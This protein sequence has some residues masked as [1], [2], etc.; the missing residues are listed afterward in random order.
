M[1][2][3]RLWVRNDPRRATTTTRKGRSGNMDTQVERVVGYVRVSTSHQAAHGWSLGEQTRHITAYCAA[4]NW[5]LAEI[6]EDAGISGRTTDRPRLSELL[7]ELADI[8]VI[9]VSSLSRLGRSNRHLQ[10][11][12]ADLEA[13]GVALVSLAESID[14]STASGKLMRNFL[15]AIAEFESEQTSERV[16]S[17]A[18]ARVR[19][20]H[21]HGGPPPYGYTHRR[22]PSGEPIKHEPWMIVPAETAIVIRIFREYLEGRSQHAIVRGLKA[23]GIPA[24][25]GEWHQGTISAILRN[26]AYIGK[27]RLGDDEFDGRHPPIVDIDTWQGVR[28]RR[29]R[30]TRTRGRGG[31][32]PP[33]A[34]FL[35]LN[36]TL[37][38]GE[39][40][41]AMVPRTDANRRD[42]SYEAYYCYGRKRDR[43]SCTQAPIPRVLVDEAVYGFF[44]K[45]GLDVERT[46]AQVAVTVEAKLGEVRAYRA[47]AERDERQARERMDR[48][49][50]DYQDG[51]LAADDWAEQRTQL[52]AESQ[53]AAAK[54]AQLTEREAQ[55]EALMDVRDGEAESLRAL[56]R[57]R[58]AIAGT[59]RAADGV[60]A[61]RAAIL[62]LFE[63]FT[64]RNFSPDATWAD[65]GPRYWE[66]DLL[67]P[68]LYIEPHVRPQAIESAAPEQCQEGEVIWPVLRRSPVRATTDNVALTR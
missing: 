52:T 34:A 55:V 66:P 31:G 64:V 33:R 51:K 7:S 24:R 20:G 44:E 28:E 56:A 60:D 57:I 39:C 6:Y 4:K 37:R 61:A 5:N 1:C 11:V 47:S 49:R 38:C 43:A 45:V 27:V 46:R 26:P 58:D 48:V 8:D 14:T 18:G 3:R 13:Q 15:A 62:S 17:A 41:E 67:L 2:R 59:I 23:D 25:R 35:F 10:E 54:L 40:G 32:R 21:H 30:L 19:G 29:E 16:R 53:G 65:D 42:G 9:V 12:F 36:G 63:G 50:R 68:G 22:G